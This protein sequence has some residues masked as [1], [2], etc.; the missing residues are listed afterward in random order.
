MRGKKKKGRVI[1]PGQETADKVGQGLLN[2]LQA[3]GLDPSQLP[4]KAV[5]GDQVLD[6]STWTY[7]SEST[8][9]DT[10]MDQ[11]HMLGNSVTAADINFKADLEDDLKKE[12]EMK[13]ESM[14]NK[15]RD[16][17]VDVAAVVDS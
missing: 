13:N 2:K 8:N 6:Q 4:K 14:K 5:D 12:E 10:T 16:K 1:K 15:A 17:T 9:V 3:A 7:Y 11:G